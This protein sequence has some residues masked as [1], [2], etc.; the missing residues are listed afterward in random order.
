MCDRHKNVY[1]RNLTKQK[2]LQSDEFEISRNGNYGI[3]VKSRY[4]GDFNTWCILFDENGNYESI[5]LLNKIR[6][7]QHNK[8][9]ECK[10]IYYPPSIPLQLIE[11]DNTIPT[12][13]FYQSNQYT[14]N[15]FSVTKQCSSNESIDESTV[16]CPI[17]NGFIPLN[18]NTDKQ[19][20]N[21]EQLNT[22]SQQLYDEMRDYNYLSEPSKII[23]STINS[24]NANTNS[25]QSDTGQSPVYY[26]MLLQSQLQ[27][28][29][30]PTGLLLI[31]GSK[32]IEESKKI[33]A[34]NNFY[35]C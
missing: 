20:N 3:T 15:Q 33:E 6:A 14:F 21:Y 8:N 34:W 24:N 4:S 7:A 1:T 10:K 22:T 9:G 29:F 25:Y 18:S 30:A 19:L 35:S 26:D 12:L 2:F 31:E 27:Y 23:T 5:K 11:F 13:P 17:L 16:Q 28:T 32:K